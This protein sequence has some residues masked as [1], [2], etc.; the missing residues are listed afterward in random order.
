MRQ[1]TNVL[2]LTFITIV[3]YAQT[4]TTRGFVE[5]DLYVFPQKAPNDSSHAIGEGLFRFEFTLKP[6]S[7]FS[8]QG[9][10]DAR[11]DTHRQTERDFHLNFWDRTIQRPAFSIRRAS[12]IY[13]QGPVT[14]ELGKQFIRWGKTDILTP[15]DRFAPRDYLSVVETEVLAV[16]AARLT[17]AKGINSLDVVYTPRMTPSRTPLLNQRWVV[18]PPTATNLPLN[19]AGAVYPGGPQFGVRWNRS[20]SRIEHSLSYFEGFNHLPLLGTDI[21]LSP[22]RLDV[23]RIYP[24][25]R[26]IGGDVAA[27]LTWLTLKGEAAWFRSDNAQADEYVLYVAQLERQQGEWLLIG[28]YAGEHVTRRRNPFDFAPDRGLARAIVGRAS[29]T[30][31][32]NRSITFEGVARQNGDGFLGKVEYSHAFGQHWRV[33]PR[34]VLIRGSASDF[35][36]Q[37][38][39]NSYASLTL[40]Y[41]F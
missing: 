17:L 7:H 26:V 25:I 20:G 10:L 3:T 39:R 27:P 4:F 15:T 30:I 11:T 18:I 33:I 2:L 1:S 32:T 19:D 41:S 9:S 13:S 35:L 36:G 8:F 38:H 40:R 37:Y 29:Y 22:P 5:T 21:Q 16:T 28:G 12:A 24:K 6:N 34:V 23:F 14:L 31:D